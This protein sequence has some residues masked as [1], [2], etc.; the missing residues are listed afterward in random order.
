MRIVSY[1]ILDGGEGRADPLT[2]TIIAQ[3]PDVVALVE[4]DDPVVID[5]IASRL[6][7]DYVHAPG[8][9]HASALL[10]RWPIVESINHAPLH[11]PDKL[12]KSF[13]E[14]LVRTP[15]LGDV[16]FGVVHLRHRATEADESIREQELSVV[17]DILAPHVA[18]RRPHVLAGDF[19]AN[20]PAQQIDP[21][22][23]KS[24]TQYDWQLN[25]GYA[26]RRV[27]QKLLDAGYIDT[28]HAV[29]ATDAEVVGTFTTQTPGQ[30]VDYIFTHSIEPSR[31]KSVWVEQDR[32]ARYA[33][34]HFPVGAEIG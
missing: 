21:A 8:N 27:V 15:D 13:L 17:L 31:I 16:T 29:C 5:R 9:S 30:R 26:P 23:C 1:N 19:N 14:V 34:D 20:H 32:L 7:M 25:G 33:S 11:P 12:T 18:A 2:E 3:R 4:A 24:R 22:K 10:S 6:K 28:L